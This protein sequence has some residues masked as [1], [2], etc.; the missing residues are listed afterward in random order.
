M[1]KNLSWEATSRL[2]IKKFSAFL[3]PEGS[4]PLSQNPVTYP[5]PE[6]DESI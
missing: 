2:V 5:C 6:P 3:E 1:E 4:S